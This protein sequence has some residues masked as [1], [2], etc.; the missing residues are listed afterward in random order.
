MGRNKCNHHAQQIMCDLAGDPDLVVIPPL[1]VVC[2]ADLAAEKARA[3]EMEAL[4]ERWEDRYC[5]QTIRADDLSRTVA[6]MGEALVAARD[7]LEPHTCDGGNGGCG[8]E[9]SNDACVAIGDIDDIVAERD[10]ALHGE[11]RNE[12]A[13]QDV[14]DALDAVPGDVLAP[15]LKVEAGPGFEVH[16]AIHATWAMNAD[17]RDICDR[18]VQ[19][20]YT[21]PSSP[22]GVSGQPGECACE[23]CEK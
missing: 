14:L 10:A 1:C 16:R 6:A 5:I 3:D 7:A 8:C 9:G 22:A 19:G 4:A 13:A 11:A 21:L 12:G 17:E 23:W 18:L 20:R 15:T 2:T